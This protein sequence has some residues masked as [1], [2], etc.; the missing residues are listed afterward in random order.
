MR[1][2]VPRLLFMTALLTLLTS[3]L[4]HAQSN[5]DC[6]SCHKDK[7][8]TKQMNRKQVSLYVDL[9]KMKAGVHADLDCI[10][11][12]K[13]VK[14]E[15]PHEPAPK[16]VSCRGCHDDEVDA[17]EKGRHASAPKRGDDKAATCAACHGPAHDIL[18]KDNPASK[19]RRGN[20][21]KLCG[22][23]HGDKATM[24]KS[25]LAT[26]TVDS[27][28]E[29]VHGKA[30]AKGETKA[31]VC[32]DCHKSHDVRTQD[33]PLSPMNRTRIADTCGECHKKPAAQYKDSV[34]GRAVAHGNSK[35]PSC[36][37]CHGIHLI[38][39]PDSPDSPVAAQ[40][41]S[42]TCGSCHESERLANEF[43]VRGGK[44]SA[45]G[46][47][48][49]GLA[50]GKGGATVANCASCHGVHNILPSDNPRSTINPKNLVDT[51]GKCHPGAKENFIQGKVHLS[52]KPTEANQ[53]AT[54]LLNE[55]PSE[56]TAN[57]KTSADWGSF[58]TYWVRI[59]YIW[60]IIGVIGG[61]LLHNFLAWRRHVI[62]RAK[63]VPRTVERLTKNQR[64]QHYLLILSFVTLAVTGFALKFPGPWA[65]F[66][67]DEL[68]RRS[69]H[70]WAGV[71]LMLLGVYHVGYLLLS[72]LGRRDLWDM[73]PRWKD[74]TDL[75][76]NLSYW[77]GFSQ[78]HPRFA[79]F[80]YAEKA[81]YWA[82]VWGTLVMA[83]TGLMLWFPV[84]SLFGV[85]PR[86]TIDLA[87]S[88][89]FYEAILAS[90][91]VPVWHFYHV[92]LSPDAYPINLA[93][94]DGMMSEE[95]FKHEHGLAWDEM[96]AAKGASTSAT[97]AEGSHEASNGP[98]S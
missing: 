69:V 53:A 63:S 71:I 79:R 44:L 10:D 67:G 76:G 21:P 87:N 94:W 88:V 45:Y 77:L 89:H 49:H 98:T 3:G 54:T 42:K 82:L 68:V 96:Q 8:L 27:Y 72:R 95:Q 29:S 84:Q 32:T 24:A 80:G 61:M 59:I 37:D 97:S 40:A 74:V 81:E 31:A 62:E 14:D 91:A 92:M 25:G 55:N 51:C 58:T 38:K 65:M 30:I 66:L 18:K 41:V 23:C 50:N 60:L 43:G 35:S 33:D 90:L 46:D 11:C 12:H 6:M 9:A 48:Y 28:S 15:E 36:N 2:L 34:H 13:G 70:R 47:S 1:A 39:A 26:K 5:S 16:A 64:L 85:L 75:F 86:W 22:S 4:A 20:I 57:D 78:K 52:S 7:E 19:T 83:I 56:A 93:F 73:L 17:Y